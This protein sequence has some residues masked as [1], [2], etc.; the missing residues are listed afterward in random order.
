[1]LTIEWLCMEIV[2]CGARYSI[3]NF[4][5]SLNECNA[6]YYCV[7]ARWRR[8]YLDGCRSWR[9]KLILSERL[10]IKR[11]S[12]HFRIK[13]NASLLYEVNLSA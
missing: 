6:L 7:C 3:I 9:T 8:I 13:K 4:C 1:L 2:I 11:K 12:L 5:Q 10:I